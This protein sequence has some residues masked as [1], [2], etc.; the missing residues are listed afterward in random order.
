[1]ETSSYHSFL[2]NHC[3]LFSLE[4]QSIL[5][6]VTVSTIFLA[7]KTTLW[8]FCH[9]ATFHTRMWIWQA[10]SNQIGFKMKNSSSIHLMWLT[11]RYL[12]FVQQNLRMKAAQ[13]IWWE[14]NMVVWYQSRVSLLA[15]HFTFTL[16]CSIYLSIQTKQWNAFKMKIKDLWLC[17]SKSKG[18]KKQ[19][20]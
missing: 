10:F 11:C 13:T 4:P 9:N 6:F 14:L 3:R 2:R 20:G 7:L 1:M 19:S 17:L 12:S 8:N 15:L 16:N 18:S 5:T